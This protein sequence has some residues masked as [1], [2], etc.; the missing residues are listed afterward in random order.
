MIAEDPVFFGKPAAAVQQVEKVPVAKPAEKILKEKPVPVGHPGGSQSRARRDE[1]A[2][3]SRDTR[4]VTIRQGRK[5]T[6]E[7]DAEEETR[8]THSLSATPPA[9]NRRVINR[10]IATI[11]KSR[12][13]PGKE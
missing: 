2:Q 4:A 7:V 11:H 1:P 5:A 9:Q 3:R 13:D 8:E 6:I 12:K 10:F